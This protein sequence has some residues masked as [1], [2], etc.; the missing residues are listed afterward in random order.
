MKELEETLF[1]L[2]SEYDTEMNRIE[3]V[4][5][6]N[7]EAIIDDT[8]MLRLWAEIT[9]IRNEIGKIRTIELKDEYPELYGQLMAIHSN[10]QGIAD[11]SKQ[12]SIKSMLKHNRLEISEVKK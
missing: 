5:K 10:I 3:S 7:S 1:R 9:E 8:D 2:E 6:D 11:E 4:I 12:E